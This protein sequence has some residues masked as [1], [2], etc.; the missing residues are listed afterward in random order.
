M[1]T[2]GKAT[3]VAMA[4]MD[5]SA[6]LNSIQTTDTTD[7]AET[8]GFQQN[9][10]TYIGGMND[11]TLAFAGRFQG[12]AATIEALVRANITNRGDIPITV[13]W[14]VGY[15]AGQPVLFG[16]GPTTS[17]KITAPIS[18]VVAIASDLQFSGDGIYDGKRVCGSAAFGATANGI[19]FDNAD[20][21]PIGNLGACLHLT[22]NTRNGTAI[23]ALQHS[24]DG[25]VW[26]DLVTFTIVAAGINSAQIIPIPS[27]IN[28]Y[29]RIVV[30]TTGSTGTVMPLVSI[31]RH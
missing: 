25:T 5:I 2:H 23:V 28:R 24:T 20:V 16:R 26:V 30:T 15:A 22:Q 6:W 4:G 31:G 14:G 3:A 13:G 11:A 29:I 19:T 27:S 17:L 21:T 8:S 7:V 10:K 12:Q 18:D 1:P 9:D